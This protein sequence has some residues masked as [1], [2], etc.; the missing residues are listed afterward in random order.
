MRCPQIVRI[1]SRERS[2][3]HCHSHAFL[4]P[5]TCRRKT[6]KICDNSPK[7][8]YTNPPK[9]LSLHLLCPEDH[10]TLDGPICANRFADSRE[11]PDSRESFEGSQTEPLFC[12]SRFGGQNIANHG[13]EAIRANRSHVT[14]IV[15]FFF[16]SIRAN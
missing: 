12:E 13:F 16:L 3:E 8:I 14:K 6:E 2:L 5:R 7:P 10:Y 4:V 1:C 15:F 11:S 9:N